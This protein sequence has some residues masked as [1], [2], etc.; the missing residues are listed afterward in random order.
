MDEKKKVDGDAYT[1]VRNPDIYNVP[2]ALRIGALHVTGTGDII[3]FCFYG[4]APSP[5]SVYEIIGRPDAEEAGTHS[6]LI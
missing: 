1:I 4:P 5:S 6:I 2:S 3:P